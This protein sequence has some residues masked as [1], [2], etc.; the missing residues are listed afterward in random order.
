[1]NN[2]YHFIFIFKSTFLLALFILIPQLAKSQQID[3]NTITLKDYYSTNYAIEKLSIKYHNVGNKQKNTNQII[4]YGFFRWQSNGWV[5]LKS[6]FDENILSGVLKTSNELPN[7]AGSYDNYL[8]YIT[9][10]KSFLTVFDWEGPLETSP[11]EMKTILAASRQSLLSML[12]FGCPCNPVGK[13]VWNNGWA[14]IQLP[15]DDASADMEMECDQQ[16]RALRMKCGFSKLGSAPSKAWTREHWLFEYEYGKAG[17]PKKMP[18]F[19]SVYFMKPTP[20]LIYRLEI[21]SLIFSTTLLPKEQFDP[22]NYI[23]D[24]VNI[25]PGRYFNKERA[26]YHNNQW[27]PINNKPED[28]KYFYTSI[29]YLFTILCIILCG[30]LFVRLYKSRKY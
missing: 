3:F 24:K 6:S 23:A 15:N 13:V 2:I 30:G 14:H 5:C 25:T 9:G 20:L 12:S 16:G 7:A 21:E 8:W 10:K 29:Y 27:I 18:S 19:V 4:G 11:K 1:M 22:Y 28:P 26:I 17:L